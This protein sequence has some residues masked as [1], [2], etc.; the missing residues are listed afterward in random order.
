MTAFNW[1]SSP[2]PIENSFA[3]VEAEARKSKDA[4]KELK[5]ENHENSLRNL[6]SLHNGRVPK[7]ALL[8]EHCFSK[9]NWNCWPEKIGLFGLFSKKT[10]FSA[11]GLAVTFQQYSKNGIMQWF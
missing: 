4:F 10:L 1:D 6:K 7:D 11:I 9:K 5:G 2:A 3:S 8:N